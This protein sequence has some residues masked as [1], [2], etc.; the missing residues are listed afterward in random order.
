M[1]A[2]ALTTPTNAPLA[3]ARRLQGR[4]AV[5]TGAAQGLGEALAHGSG[6]R[7]P[8]GA[9]RMTGRRQAEAIARGT[10]CV[11]CGPTRT[12]PIPSRPGWWRRNSAPDIAVSAASLLR[13][14]HRL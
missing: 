3:D 14:H 13:R 12:S 5:V 10:A 4:V 1:A 9:M 8:N 6:A 7:A 11:P 2:N